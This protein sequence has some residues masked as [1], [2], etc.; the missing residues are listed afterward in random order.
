MLICIGPNEKVSNVNLSLSTDLNNPYNPLV[1][2]SRTGFGSFETD[3]RNIYMFF[4]HI[5]KFPH[6]FCCCFKKKKEKQIML[7]I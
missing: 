1:Q 7:D 2:T 3:L 5:L 6:F 4:F